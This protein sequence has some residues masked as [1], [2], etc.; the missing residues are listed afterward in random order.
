MGMKAYNVGFTG[1]NFDS[2]DPGLNSFDPTIA[3][4]SNSADGGASSSS[5]YATEDAKP[6]QKMQINVTVN[7]ATAVKQT[8]EIFQWLDSITVRYKAELVPAGAATYAMIPETSHEGLL[9]V[10]AGTGGTVSWLQNGDLSYRG[11]DAAAAPVLTIGC[12][13]I[14]YRSLFR[15]SGIIPFRVTYIRYTVTTSPQISNKF[16][17]F[18]KTIA[19]GEIANPIN[20][21]SYFRPNQFQ[22][23]TIDLPVTFD[24]NINSGLQIP[25]EANENIILA[26]FIDAWTLQDLS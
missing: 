10:V 23:D 21:R 24:V 13:E 3:R 15:A 17:W 14:G 20:P 7:N 12:S 25:I 18:K 1:K 8:A 6:G 22:D 4:K 5:A 16:R 11:N 2:F 26:L 9:R 19:G